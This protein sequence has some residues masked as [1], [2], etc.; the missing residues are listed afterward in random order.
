MKTTVWTAERIE[1]L[2]A[3][4]AE[5]KSAA[6]I[7]RLLGCGLTRNAVFGKV[8]RLDLTTHAAPRKPYRTFARTWM[9]EETPW[10]KRENTPAAETPSSLDIPFLDLKASHC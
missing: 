1:T 6:E 5:R 9:P 8:H 7:A 3:L 10:K 4:W 2:K